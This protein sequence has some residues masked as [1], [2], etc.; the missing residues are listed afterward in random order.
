MPWTTETMQ[1]HRAGLSMSQRRKWC[2]IANGI[3][4]KCISNGGDDTSCS[5]KAIKIANSNFEKM[6]KRVK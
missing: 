3:L 6:G 5:P 4:S 2:R 1:K